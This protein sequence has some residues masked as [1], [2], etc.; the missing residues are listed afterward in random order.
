[1]LDLEIDPKLRGPCQPPRL[2]VDV[3]RAP[4]EMLLE[5]RHRLEG[6]EAYLDIRRYADWKTSGRLCVSI[7]KVDLRHRGQLEPRQVDRR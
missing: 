5:F 6:C 4:R 3:N 1:M 2:P 7:A